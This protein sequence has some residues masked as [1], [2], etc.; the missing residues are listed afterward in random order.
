VI[1]TSSVNQPALTEDWTL[2]LLPKEEGGVQRRQFLAGAPLALSLCGLPA[3]P[4][5]R[6]LPLPGG[7]A[8]QDMPGVAEVRDTAQPQPYVPVSQSLARAD[9]A[10]EDVV[11]W[12]VTAQ[13]DD[14]LPAFGLTAGSR[15]AQRNGYSPV[16]GP[17]FWFGYNTALLSGQDGS[18]A[19]AAVGLSCFGDAGDSNNGS[20]GHGLEFNPASFRSADGSAVTNALQMVALDD[21]TN[22]VSWPSAAAPG[23]GRPR[24]CRTRTLPLTT[25]DWDPRTVTPSSARFLSR[26]PVAVSRTASPAGTPRGR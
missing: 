7:G 21:N 23:T 15:T 18:A 19:H 17:A 20:G 12:T 11:Q 8:A 14:P 16:Q 3:K 9:G 4:R 5:V 6:D 10:Y 13:A 22:T 2:A 1:G 25:C 24:S 26:F